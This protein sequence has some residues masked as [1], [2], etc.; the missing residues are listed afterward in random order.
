M[1]CS[2]PRRPHVDYA[3]ERPAEHLNSARP[4]RLEQRNDR[5][6]NNRTYVPC[7][8]V[9]EPGLGR[10]SRG[11]GRER[12]CGSRCVPLRT[13]RSKSAPITEAIQDSASQCSHVTD[14]MQRGQTLAEL[15][16]QKSALEAVLQMSAVKNDPLVQT[17]HAYCICI[18]IFDLPATAVAPVAPSC[19]LPS[20]PPPP[21]STSSSL[22]SPS[23]SSSTSTLHLPV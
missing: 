10:C 13:R 23:L 2:Y 15:N 19:A 12:C 11:V 5:L 17:S 1:L 7:V 4:A 16:A 20:P 6:D 18:K 22:S 3:L 8:D 21:P 9:A 14:G